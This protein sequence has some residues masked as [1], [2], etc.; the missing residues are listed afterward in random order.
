MACLLWWQWH[1]LVQSHVVWSEEWWCFVW[2]WS[3]WWVDEVVHDPLD[4]NL[5]I[6]SRYNRVFLVIKNS[7]VLVHH[8]LVSTSRIHTCSACCIR[9]SSGAVS[10]LGCSVERFLLW[11]ER[12]ST[13]LQ[14]PSLGKSS[15][16]SSTVWKV[17]DGRWIGFF[18]WWLGCCARLL[19]HVLEDWKSSSWFQTHHASVEVVA[20]IRCLP[21]F[22]WSWTLRYCRFGWCPW[23]RSR[24]SWL[25][26]CRCIE[27]C[28][29][30]DSLIW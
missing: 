1:W 11:Q 12:N 23:L 7:L 24:S 28:D 18:P 16:I 30:V 10:S 9:E 8:E 5:D 2:R 29:S 17:D 22:R 27:Q 26:C 20:E 21:E 15:S 25:L 14:S 6:L 4:V 13:S 19:E 3:C